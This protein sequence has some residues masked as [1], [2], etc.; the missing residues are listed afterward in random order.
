[1]HDE[2]LNMINYNEPKL[3]GLNYIELKFKTG[4]KKTNRN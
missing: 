1:M 3:I 2:G 4:A